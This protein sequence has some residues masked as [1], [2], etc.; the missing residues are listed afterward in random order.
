[1]KRAITTFVGLLVIIIII[2]ITIINIV[3]I[4]IIINTYMIV[5]QLPNT[6]LDNGLAP[7]RWQ[8]IIKSNV[9]P[10]GGGGELT[11]QVY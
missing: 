1:M 4:I 3:I 11:W 5:W 9:P 8:A 6:G 7:N 10:I 2:I